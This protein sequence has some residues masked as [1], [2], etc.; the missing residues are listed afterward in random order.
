M[1]LCRVESPCHF[2][3]YCIYSRDKQRIGMLVVRARDLN[4][5]VTA[6]TG[7]LVRRA[8]ASTGIRSLKQVSPSTA[9]MQR[10][11]ST[12]EISLAHALKKRV[13]QAT[14][15]QYTLSLLITK[16]CIGTYTC[17]HTCKDSPKHR[18]MYPSSDTSNE[19]SGYYRDSMQGNS[20]H[21]GV[22]RSPITH[23]SGTR[24]LL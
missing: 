5:K 12:A 8:G 6:S 21:L 19:D 16:Q 2:L 10:A 18:H 15:S 4:Q 1:L 22:A 11:K 3:S 9:G 24:S 13:Q 7:N 14:K 20:Y 23:T 17:K